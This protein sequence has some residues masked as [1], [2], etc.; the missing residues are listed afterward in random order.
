MTD[1]SF[2]ASSNFDVVNLLKLQAIENTIQREAKKIDELRKNEELS[3]REERLREINEK[4][5]K[6]EKKYRELETK[7][8]KMEDEA[9]I[10]SEKIRRN[11][12]KLFSGTITSAK[13]LMN[14]QN[15]V[16]ILKESN[17]ELENKILEY[18]IEID[19][20]LEEIKEARER[21]EKLELCISSL[22]KDLGEKVELVEKRIS[23]L[24]EE[25]KN[26]ISIIPEEYLQK[27][28]ELK[29]KKAGIAVGYL[30]D[31]FCS[32]CSM[33]I[34]AAESEKMTN[35]HQIYRCPLCGRMIMVYRE[36]ID[37]ISEEMD[38]I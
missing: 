10:Q 18:M 26:T 24:N 8:K 30:R 12:Q 28:E 13:E 14:L 36:E 35:L 19:D 6:L 7:R 3:S 38:S 17:E 34:P 25:R 32:A 1:F 9:G 21:K 15:E 5:D 31:G 27:Y 23:A 29:N 33:E 16:K 37:R 4:L 2:S 20:V 11:E 22:K